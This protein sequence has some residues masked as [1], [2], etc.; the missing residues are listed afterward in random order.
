[1]KYKFFAFFMLSNLK[2]FPKTNQCITFVFRISK[3]LIKVDA[4]N[5]ERSIPKMV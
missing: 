2:G 4:K 1:M 3:T 5:N